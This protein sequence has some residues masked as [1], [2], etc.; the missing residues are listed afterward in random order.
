MG[1]ARRPAAAPTPILR[2][3][4]VSRRYVTEAESV[5]AVDAV[6]MTGAAGEFI[7][8]FGHSGSGKTTLLN[9]LAGL[10]LPTEGRVEV[11]GRVTSQMSESDRIRLRRET[12]GVVHQTDL[13]IEEFTAEEN[14]ALP[15]EARGVPVAEALRSAG[16]GLAVVGLAGHEQRLP[17][18]LSGGQRQRVGI[19]RALAGGRRA[20]LADEPTG[21]LDTENAAGIFRLFRDL[22]EQ[23]ALVVIASHDPACRDYATRLVEM[24]DGAVVVPDASC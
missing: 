13:L 6:D 4:G 19:A 8:L 21:A 1:S 10:D 23:G 5:A 3:V 12:V 11:D 24:R 15:L 2:T 9:L 20:L 18:Q 7:V 22:S 16:D 14:V 17:R